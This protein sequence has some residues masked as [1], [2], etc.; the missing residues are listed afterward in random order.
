MVSGNCYLVCQGRAPFQGLRSAVGAGD[1]R[2]R[3]QHV[4]AGCHPP[5][6]RLNHQP[7]RPP[8]LHSFKGEA[9]YRPPAV[10]Y[11]EC[12]QDPQHTGHRRQAAVSAAGRPLGIL[13]SGRGEH[14]LYLGRLHAAA[15]SGHAGAAGWHGGWQPQTAPAEG[16]QT[17]GNSPPPLADS[18]LAIVAGVAAEEFE[19]PVALQETGQEVAR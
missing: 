18:N 14:R 16:G 15:P 1:V 13:P 9:A 12:D 7:T 19:D 17:V 4:V 5:P 10:A 6:D 3:R 11:P 2:P 8:P